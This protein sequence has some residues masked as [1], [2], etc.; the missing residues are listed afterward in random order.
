MPEFEL[1][2]PAGPRALLRGAMQEASD[3]PDHRVLPAA[4]GRDQAGRPGAAGT[5][6]LGLTGD[7]H[8]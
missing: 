4:S 8:D 6:R 7:Y 1:G 5:R 2:W 3:D